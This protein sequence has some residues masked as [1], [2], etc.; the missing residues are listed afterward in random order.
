[1]LTKS[2]QKLIQ[3]LKLKKF[4]DR[5]GL[6]VVEGIKPIREFLNSEMELHS[7]FALDDYFKTQ[8][9]Q[10]EEKQL[11]KISFLKT[12]QKALALFRIPD[13]VEAI[14]E[15]LILALDSVR[16]PGNLGT[17]IRMCHWFGVKNIICSEDTV[18]C[19]N[20]KVVQATMGSLARVNLHYL[21]LEDFLSQSNLPKFVTTLD[22]NSIYREQL[23]E[24]AILVMGNEANGISNAILSLVDN[25]ITI[26]RFQ[27]NSKIES[28]NVA[29]A[30][31]IC[32]NEFRRNL[33]KGKV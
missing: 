2:Q 28:L 4:R 1:M 8:F 33:L 24:N 13:T 21:H 14:A 5:E 19:Y 18:D 3:S 23:P 16:D 6:F 25:R 7:L 27:N 32:L 30:T 20:P 12:P 15:E 29:T 17:I 9:I 11:A 22:G 10:I 26:P 31:S